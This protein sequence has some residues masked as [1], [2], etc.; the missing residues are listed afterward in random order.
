VKAISEAAGCT[1]RKW[2][3]A[4]DV[5]GRWW[6]AGVGVKWLWRQSEFPGG[7][8]GRKRQREPERRPW[9]GGGRSAAGRR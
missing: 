3:T 5:V 9:A 6:H 2:S 8:G 4:A 1:P 7:V